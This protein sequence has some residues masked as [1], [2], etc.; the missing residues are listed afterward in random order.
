[1]YANSCATKYP[2]TAVIARITTTPSRREITQLNATT[3][4]RRGYGVRLGRDYDCR[5]P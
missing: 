1:M 4:A 5:R 2:V 3:S